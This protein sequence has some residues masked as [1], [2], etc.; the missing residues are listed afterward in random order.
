MMR[1]YVQFDLRYAMI[2]SE[3]HIIF[4]IMFASKALKALPVIGPYVYSESF[5]VVM[6]CGS[7][8]QAKPLMSVLKKLHSPTKDL[9]SYFGVGTFVVST[10]LSLSLPGLILIGVILN[11]R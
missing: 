6:F 10:A 7:Q 1:A 4:N 11:P 5:L 9:I 3:Q 8:I 2:G